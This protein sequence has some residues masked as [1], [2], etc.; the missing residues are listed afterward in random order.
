MHRILKPTGS[1]YL[2]CDPTASH[3]LKLVLDAIFGPANFLNEIAWQRTH[4]HGSSRRYGP[5]H[6]VILFYAKSPKYKWTGYRVA[7]DPE[8]TAEHFRSTDQ[9]GRRFQPI[10]LTGSGV[11]HGDSGRPW[12]GVDPTRVRRHWAIPGEVVRRLDLRGV[13][14]QE[15]LDSLDAAGRIYWPEKGGGTPRLKWYAD[16]LKGV[17]LPDV[18]TDIS[19]IGAQ[20][21]ERMGYPTQK[22]LAL[23][24]RIVAA[25]SRPGDV[26]LDPFCGCGTTIDA[27]ETL[28]RA[29]RR[30]KKRLWIGI[31]ITHIAINLIKMRLNRFRPPPQYEVHGEPQTFSEAEALARTDP[32]EF[33]FWALGQIG[34]RSTGQAK[35]KGADRGI[36]GV[37]YFMDERKGG[38][39]VTKRMLVQ[40]KGGRVKSGDIRDFVGTLAREGAEMGVFLTLEEPSQPM[41]AE[42]ASA[43]MYISPWDKQ[44]YPKVQVLTIEEL[45]RDPQR[46]NPRCLQVPAG[47]E[48]TLPQAPRHTG[49]PPRQGRLGLEET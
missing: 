13:T 48:H 36:D 8:Y 15:K 6:D 12:R 28:N 24:K 16:E 33:Q 5:V 42:A 46:P 26:V 7:H 3:Y 4:A 45:L 39:L 14:V 40:V 17:A 35:K 43:G 9:D 10:T 32:Y 23:L 38:A 31:D 18:I 2:H 11:R 1:L 20:A 19:P 30:K 21:A 25:S 44:P 37:R 27:V 47:G 49:G 22:P 34:A 41:K 29:T